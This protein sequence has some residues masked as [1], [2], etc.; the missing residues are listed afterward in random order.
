M[1]TFSQLPQELQYR[2]R[3]MALETLIESVLEG[4][5]DFKPVKKENRR[6]LNSILA[7]ARK[8][9]H[10]ELAKNVIAHDESL[11][12]EFKSLADAVAEGCF[13]SDEGEVIRDALTIPQG[14]ADV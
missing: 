11:Y 12:Q 6:L 13:F 9:E 4:F 8:S 10:H 2:A 14:N 7:D 1:R 5:V 3:K